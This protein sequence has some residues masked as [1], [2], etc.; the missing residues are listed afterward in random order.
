MK[1]SK[2]IDINYER[3][4]NKYIVLDLEK[5]KIMVNNAKINFEINEET[6]ISA[7]YDVIQN[8]LMKLIDS[9][10]YHRLLLN[11]ESLY[12]NKSDN[13]IKLDFKN[14]KEIICRDKEEMKSLLIDIINQYYSNEELSNNKYTNEELRNMIKQG[15]YTEEDYKNMKI[16]YEKE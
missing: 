5:L 4:K 2:K 9:N 1:E 6:V 14:Y 8:D 13:K 3:H 12:I 7:T 11:M 10:K 15:F 16:I